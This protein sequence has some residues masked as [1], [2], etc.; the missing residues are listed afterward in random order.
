MKYALP[1]ILIAG[2]ATAA[3]TDL[4]PTAES[5]DKRSD[6]IIVS[7]EQQA[8]CVSDGGCVLIPRGVIRRAIEQAKASRT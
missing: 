2:C 6:T 5:C 4:L 3:P 1:L 8:E 7:P